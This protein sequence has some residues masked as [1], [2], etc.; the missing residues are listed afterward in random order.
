MLRKSSLGFHDFQGG[1]KNVQ[2]LP[3]PALRYLTR[4]EG[5]NAQK[6]LKICT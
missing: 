5:K 6:G 3:I 4:G 2:I 1:L